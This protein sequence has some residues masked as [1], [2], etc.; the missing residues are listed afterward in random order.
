MSIGFEVEGFKELERALAGMNVNTAK[1]VARRTMKK[2]LKPIAS[3]ANA[4]WPGSSDN[5]FVVTSRVAKRQ[6]QPK[7]GRA[8]LNMFVGAAGTPKAHLLEFGT[9]PRYQKN[10][11]Y[12]GSVAPQPMLQPAWD[13]HKATML[14]ELKKRL[15]DEIEKTF[16]RLAAKG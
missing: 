5:V 7:K 8:I 3:M 10:G 11:R 9:G 15:G 12:T 13:A 4:F 2:E 1:G 6:P 16:A 14:T